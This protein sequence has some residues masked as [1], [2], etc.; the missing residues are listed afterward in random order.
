MSVI[1]PLPPY[2]PLGG[3][4]GT[5]SVA[6][7]KVQLNAKKGSRKDSLSFSAVRQGEGCGGVCVCARV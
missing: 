5:G 4:R 7:D 6:A 1:D 3:G 2:Q